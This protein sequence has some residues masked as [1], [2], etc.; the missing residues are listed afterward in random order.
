[1]PRS[2]LCTALL[3]LLIPATL[4]ASPT[5][6]KFKLNTTDGKPWSLDNDAKDK[7]AVVVLFIGTQCPVNN[8]Y[9]P[10]LIE[11]EKEYRAKGVQFVAINSNEHDKFETIKEHAKKF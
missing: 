6:V 1:M 8:A 10:K 4:D 7:K 11:L 5:A 2:L 9:M 3:A